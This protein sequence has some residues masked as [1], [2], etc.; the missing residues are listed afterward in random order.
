MAHLPIN[1]PLRPAYRLLAGLTGL[2]LLA[3]GAVGWPGQADWFAQGDVRAFGLTTNRAL[4][5]ATLAAGM[6]VLAAAIIGRNVD[7]LVN[8]WGGAVFLI[9]GTVM[10]PLSHSELNVLNSS[11]G[12]AIAAYVV[13]LLLIAAGLYG[14]AG[15]VGEAAAQEAVRHRA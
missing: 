2:A 6:V 7:R 9:V 14:K 8:L 12:T 3:F 1:H 15:S 4:A 11:V 10:M 13:G 5:L